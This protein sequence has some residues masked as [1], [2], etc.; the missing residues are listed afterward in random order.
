M[1]D[2]SQIYGR[3]GKNFLDH[4]SV[5]HSK[6]E[7]VRLDSDGVLVTT[8]TAEGLF[9]NLRRQLDG[10]HH[11]TSQKHLARYLEEFDF[12]YNNRELSDVER[13]EAAIENIEGRRLTL[14]KSVEGGES[15]YSRRPGEVRPDP[16]A[17][18]ERRRCEALTA[19]FRSPRRAVR[20][21]SREAPSCTP[22]RTLAPPWPSSPLGGA[23]PALAACS[24][25]STYP[26]R[27]ARRRSTIYPDPRRSPS[28]RSWTRRMRAPQTP[29]G[30]PRDAHAGSGLPRASAR[31]ARGSSRS[32]LRVDTVCRTVRRPSRSSYSPP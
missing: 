17:P 25:T 32:P 6:E 11:H 18:D 12:K 8:N 23:A 4:R 16:S 15:L 30:T 19:P 7:Y 1:T 5:N 22:V 24:T 10:T 13:T 3:V 2:D 21:P 29:Q 20:Y 28:R 14:Y 27:P 9:A 26:A 31:R